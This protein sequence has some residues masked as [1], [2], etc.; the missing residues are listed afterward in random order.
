M[1]SS[2]IPSIHLRRQCAR[3]EHRDLP[4][5]I[6]V[7]LLANQVEA[8]YP[9]LDQ[10]FAAFATGEGPPEAKDKLES[11]LQANYDTL[12][13]KWGSAPSESKLQE[14]LHTLESVEFML[15]TPGSSDED[16]SLGRQQ[17]RLAQLL[18]LYAGDAPPLPEVPV[19]RQAV[20]DNGLVALPLAVALGDLG[21][22]VEYLE[23]AL[24]DLNQRNFLGDR[25][26]AEL[27]EAARG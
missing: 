22:G 12:H 23:A 17:L 20:E 2:G 8:A 16:G 4:Q 13:E 10:L 24:H 27:L 19:L 6:I 1:D 25:R 9:V 18:P 14:I 21:I 11:F 15:R 26:L 3:A 7:G 5:G